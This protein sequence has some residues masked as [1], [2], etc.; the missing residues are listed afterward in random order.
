MS[1]DSRILVGS[2]V[3]MA[4]LEAGV[5]IERDQPF[6]LL[7]YYHPA[8]RGAQ[9]HN[10]RTPVKSGISA[11]MSSTRQY[12][13][14]ISPRLAHNSFNTRSLAL[15]LAL[16]FAKTPRFIRDQATFVILG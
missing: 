4:E 10:S 12:R 9:P 2:E 7:R 1:W 8:T 5:G 6:Q 11:R 15:S 13:R 3:V 16:L 14:N